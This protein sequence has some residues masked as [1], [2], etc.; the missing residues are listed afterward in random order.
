MGSGGHGY[1]Q[2][3]PLSHTQQRLFRMEFPVESS[4]SIPRRG[5][6][7]TTSTWIPQESWDSSGIVEWFGMTSPQTLPGMRQPQIP[8]ITHPSPSQGKEFLPQTLQIPLSLRPKTRTDP[9]LGILSKIYW[10]EA[11]GATGTGRNSRR[12]RRIPARSVLLPPER[13]AWGTNRKPGNAAG[14]GFVSVW[15]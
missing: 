10:W 2:L 13:A 11:E 1:S 15:E 5:I 7:G 4:W 3:F 8:R 14:G 9:I 6:C 12:L